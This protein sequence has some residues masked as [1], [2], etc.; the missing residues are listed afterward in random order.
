MSKF[1][2]T[3]N[4]IFLVFLRHYG[5]IICF[6]ISVILWDEIFE[7]K[8]CICLILT[9]Y[10][11]ESICSCIFIL[12]ILILCY[13]SKCVKMIIGSRWVCYFLPC[14]FFILVNAYSLFRLFYKLRWKR[15]IK[16]T[17]MMF[18]L[19]LKFWS[20]ISPQLKLRLSWNFIYFFKFVLVFI[21]WAE[22]LESCFV[23]IWMIV[24]VL[25]LMH[26]S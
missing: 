9:S 11:I 16:F 18:C 24:S 7:P 19:W 2:P 25:V 12:N 20:W 3:Y 5:E 10:W 21:I 23:L 22:R 6:I 26:I 1:S 14:P 17:I 15:Y 13:F 8:P 4:I